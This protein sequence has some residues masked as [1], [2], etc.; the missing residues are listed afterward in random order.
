MVFSLRLSVTWIFLQSVEALCRKKFLETPW[1][2]EVIILHDGTFSKMLASGYATRK[3]KGTL[4]DLCEV[5]KSSP[6]RLSLL[7]NRSGVS[8]TTSATSL[9]R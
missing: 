9:E 5:L 7:G 6:G 3:V 2:T 1:D 4:L 8:S